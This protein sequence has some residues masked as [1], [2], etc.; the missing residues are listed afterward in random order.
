LVEAASGGAER[1]ED[2]MI[3]RMHVESA[4]RLLRRVD[5]S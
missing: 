2:E 4:E 1:F 5:R 3:E